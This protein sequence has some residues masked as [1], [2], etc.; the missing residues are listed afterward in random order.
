MAWKVLR[1]I[2]SFREIIMSLDFI[3]M[4][5]VFQFCFLLLRLV[6][7]RKLNDRNYFF[8]LKN[9]EEYAI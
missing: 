2:P 5:E 9:F 3:I 4:V 7:V 1:I 8:F 6:F